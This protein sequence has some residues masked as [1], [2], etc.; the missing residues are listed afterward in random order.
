MSGTVTGQVGKVRLHRRDE[1][2]QGPRHLRW[3]AWINGAT[4]DLAYH[5]F[6]EEQQAVADLILE[7]LG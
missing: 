3:D 5:P 7:K 4:T 1:G 2:Q 6:A